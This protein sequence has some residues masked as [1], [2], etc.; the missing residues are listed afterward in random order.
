MPYAGGLGRLAPAPT[1]TAQDAA[2]EDEV[3][4]VRGAIRLVASRL[5]IRVVLCGLQAP[6]SAAAEVE[7]DARI[8]GVPLRLERSGN[9]V[10]ELI[11]GPLEA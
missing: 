9:V 10:I 8:A 4:E 7:L 11:V 5:A 3:R 2:N 1:R 6:E